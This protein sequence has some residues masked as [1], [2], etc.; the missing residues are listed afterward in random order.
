[1]I[2]EAWRETETGVCVFFSSFFV[3]IY[4]IFITLMLD[5]DSSQKSY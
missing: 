1:M 3:Y 5:C 4:P 2:D